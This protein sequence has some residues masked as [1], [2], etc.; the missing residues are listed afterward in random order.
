MA[1]TTLELSHSNK[2]PFPERY[3]PQS[4]QLK[5]IGTSSLAMIGIGDH[6]G[7]ISIETKRY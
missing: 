1:S 6:I 7:A 4:T 3:E 5:K 2:T